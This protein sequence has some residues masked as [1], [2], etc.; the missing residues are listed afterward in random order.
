VTYQGTLGT[1]SIADNSITIAKLK[2]DWFAGGSPELPDSTGTNNSFFVWDATAGGFAKLAQASVITGSL[3]ALGTYA[4]LAVLTD[5]VVFQ[6]A[7]TNYNCPLS[8]LFAPV[9][10]GQAALSG[11]ANV[12]I[13]AD[14]AVIASA[15]A[16]AGT[17]P[18][19]KVSPADLVR[20]VTDRVI[21][22]TGTASAYVL[23]TGLSLPSLADGNRFLVRWN[24]TNAQGATLNVDGLGAKPIRRNDDSTPAGGEI[25]TGQLSEVAYYAN[26]NSGGGSWQLVGAKSGGGGATGIVAYGKLVLVTPNP[27]TIDTTFISTTEIQIAQANAIGI[28][29]WIWCTANQGDFTKYIPYYVVNSRQSSATING[30][31]VSTTVIRV[32]TTLGGTPKTLTTPYNGPAT[33][34]SVYRSFGI[35]AGQGIG[36]WIIRSDRPA[37]YY[38]VWF[39]TPQSSAAYTVLLTPS[40]KSTYPN[41][42][43][44]T[45]VINDASYQPTTSGFQFTAVDGLNTSADF[46]SV[47]VIV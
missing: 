14:R 25:V 21:T 26:G 3:T 44:L 29:D 4:N 5:T 9:V 32:S 42:P 20:A 13:T 40:H 22:S 30:Q 1:T 33:F 27:L 8:L 16:G 17:N 31:T 37:A 47:A 7:G 10:S 35:T 15:A 11:T 43:W 24:I 45:A 6:D 23:T 34:Q 41:G 39:Q 28:N 12:N 38:D 18:N 46:V 19:R 2:N 36:A